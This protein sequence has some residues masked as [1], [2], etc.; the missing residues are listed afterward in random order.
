MRETNSM[1]KLCL[2]VYLCFVIVVL[3]FGQVEFRGQMRSPRAINILFPLPFEDSDALPERAK[4]ARAGHLAFSG[5]DMSTSIF[6]TTKTVVS[7]MS[8]VSRFHLL[9]KV[10]L[11]DNT[12]AQCVICLWQRS[13]TPPG[14]VSRTLLEPLVYK[15]TPMV[16][17][18]GKVP[19]DETHTTNAPAVAH[20]SHIGCL[21]PCTMPAH[22]CPVHGGHSLPLADTCRGRGIRGSATP[23]C[24]VQV[25]ERSTR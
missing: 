16:S 12:K 24:Y 5:T 7:R 17:P 8:R 18:T 11:D 1:L 19:Y 3:V 25:P 2:C 6:A 15:G 23:T 20:A 22:G 21:L 13:L 10:S 9:L 4:S 14:P